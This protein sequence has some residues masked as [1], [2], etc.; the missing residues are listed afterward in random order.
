MMSK[1]NGKLD[2]EE[3]KQI[4]GIAFIEDNFVDKAKYN[5][6]QIKPSSANV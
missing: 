4:D 1:N 2:I 6:N 5:L 3:L